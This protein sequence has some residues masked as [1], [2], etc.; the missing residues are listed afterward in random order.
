MNDMRVKYD[1]LGRT[2]KESGLDILQYTIPAFV[3]CN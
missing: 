1:E 3:W 2:V